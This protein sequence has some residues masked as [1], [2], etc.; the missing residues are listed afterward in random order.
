MAALRV[1]ADANA[2]QAEEFKARVKTLESENLAKEQEITSLSHKN[3]VLEEEVEKLETKIKEYKGI[4]DES[5][6]S[7]RNAEGL[8][9][10]VQLLEE[11]AEEA[12]RNIRELNEKYGVPPM[13]LDLYFYSAV[14]LTVCPGCARPTSSP[15]TTNARCKLWKR[16]KINRRPSTRS[17]TRHTKRQRRSWRTLSPR[18][19]T[20]SLLLRC[21]VDGEH[22]FGRGLRGTYISYCSDGSVFLLGS[23]CRLSLMMPCW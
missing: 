7:G 12:D 14:K 9:R 10:K 16:R 4:A 21:D 5:S 17:C 3:Q 11:E 23:D 18:S 20:S 15:D 8:Q 1:E 22:G 19:A 2:S 13:A 6:H